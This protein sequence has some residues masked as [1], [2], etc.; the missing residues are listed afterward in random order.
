MARRERKQKVTRNTRVFAPFPEW[1]DPDEVKGYEVMDNSDVQCQ[2]P[3]TQRLARTDK[4][5]RIMVVPLSKS[6]AEVAR[7]EM[8]HAKWSPKDRPKCKSALGKA[9]MEAVEEARVNL[10]LKRLKIPFTAPRA[11][12][13]SM[14]DAQS[15]DVASRKS[16]SA[17]IRAVAFQGC[18]L[19]RAMNKILKDAAEG[20]DN[21]RAIQK[22][23]RKFNRKMT[24]AKLRRLS[25]L[26]SFKQGYRISEWLESE[27]LKFVDQD[28]SM[29]AKVVIVQ[30]PGGGGTAIKKKAQAIASQGFYQRLGEFKPSERMASYSV[31]SNDFFRPNW[32]DCVPGTMHIHHPKLVIPVKDPELERITKARACEEGT[33]FR[34]IERYVSDQ[35]V[36]RRRAKKKKGGGTVLLDVSSTMNFSAADVTRIVEGAPE[37]TK[38]ATYCGNSRDGRLSIV[39]DKGKRASPDDVAHR[40]GIGNNVDIHAL[41]WLSHQP[42]PRVW[43]TDGGVTGQGHS[44]DQIYRDACYEIVDENGIIECRYV[45]QAVAALRRE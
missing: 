14:R 15:M 22:I 8:A 37:A 45:K 41:D 26:P 1:V 6:G 44:C 16:V 28:F 23:V 32:G 17:T 7:H 40:Y 38:V 25:P 21:A 20:D 4:A 10:G 2:W 12:S 35:R 30:M 24:L 33:E 39:V 5:K 34:H 31:K 11:Y 18:S 42:A 13:E 36:F 19:E 3:V 9:C 29:Q 27:I 43:I